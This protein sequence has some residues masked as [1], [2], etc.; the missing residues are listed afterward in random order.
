MSQSTS[1]IDGAGL[2]ERGRLRWQCRRGMLELD[3]LLERFVDSEYDQLGEEQQRTIVE[4]LRHPDPQLQQWLI[5]GDEPP[6]PLRQ[7][8][9]LLRSLPAS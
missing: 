8:V 1:S 9:L 4:L 7:L 5:S 2:P 3:D 6:Q